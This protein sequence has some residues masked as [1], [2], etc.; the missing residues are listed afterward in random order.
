MSAGL[1]DAQV[2]GGDERV[3]LDITIRFEDELTICVLTGPL[4]AYTAPVLDGWLEQLRTNGQD[5]LV[6]DAAEVETLS[7]HGVGVLA[8]HAARLRA[9]GGRLHVRAPSTSALR[10]LDLC[11]A[12]HLVEGAGEG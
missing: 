8:A 6:V 11:D 5:K 9:G 3:R 10:V 2:D 1:V 4:C 12:G 7:S